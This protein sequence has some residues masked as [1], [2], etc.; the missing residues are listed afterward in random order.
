MCGLGRTAPWEGA[1]LK[2]MLP[3]KNSVVLYTSLNNHSK[4]FQPSK[5]FLRSLSNSSESESNI[6]WLSALLIVYCD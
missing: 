2:E 6:V 4:T 5:E 3:L 1:V